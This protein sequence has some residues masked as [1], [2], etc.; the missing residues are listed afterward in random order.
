MALKR[1]LLLSALKLS[2]LLIMVVAF[3]AA[4]LP[5]LHESRAV[6]FAEFFAMRVKVQ[7]FLI[8]SAM[9]LFWHILLC[10]FRLYAS[11]RLSSR[12]EELG[13]ILKATFC[14]TA[15]VGIAALL[16]RITMVTSTFLVIFWALSGFLLITSRLGLRSL[17]SQV[18]L[19]GRNLRDIVI[20]GTNSR[21][22]DFARKIQSKLNLGYR[23]LGFAD[24]PWEG[25]EQFRESRYR[26]ICT[27][28]DLPHFLRSNAV[29]EVLIALPLRSFHDVA[30]RI[31]TLCEEQGIILRT[32]PNIFDLRRSRSWTEDLEGDS[33]ITHHNGILEGWPLALKR[34]L[35]FSIALALLIFL[36]PIMLVTALLVKLTSHGPVFFVQKRVGL[37]KREFY[38][39]KFRSMVADAEKKMSEIEHLNQVTGPVFKMTH[40]PRITPLGKFLRKT[41]LDELP[42][43]LN[44]VKGEMSLVGP[45]PLPVRDYKG[46]SED[47][48]RRRFSV[49]PGIT[50]LWQISG[51]SSIP[52]ERWMELDLQYIDKWSLWLDL[53]I[54]ARTIPAVLKG[55]GA[56]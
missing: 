13:R 32:L 42:Q 43:L 29:D 22:V 10:A 53:Q 31:A 45:R 4:T 19:H 18:R 24:Q 55:S 6:S 37:H 52:F 34:I 51:R 54:L 5:V 49:R 56:A 25:L 36:L 11:H 38:V 9:L 16:F 15:A 17:L 35:D 40:D 50:C 1:R 44:V 48:Q 46:F 41:S 28:D 30:S 7:N 12:N 47:W 39:Y 26:L 20:V 8:F 21:G 2:D 33:L 27:L 14:A 3:A 23:V